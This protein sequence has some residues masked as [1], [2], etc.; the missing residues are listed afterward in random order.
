M[1]GDIELVTIQ[2]K[3]TPS[4]ES[5]TISYSYS[6]SDSDS[7]S[8]S[9]SSR[10]SSI[11]F[12]P[13]LS[14]FYPI[15]K[16][17]ALAKKVDDVLKKFIDKGRPEAEADNFL[18]TNFCVNDEA[19]SCSFIFSLIEI[20]EDDYVIE[21][22]LISMLIYLERYFIYNEKDC[23]HASNLKLFVLCGAWLATKTLEDEPLD[24]AKLVALSGKTKDELKALETEFL[25]KLEW[26]IDIS[27]EIHQKSCK[28]LD[29]YQPTE[30]AEVEDDELLGLAFV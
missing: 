9:L 21:N 5:P 13:V 15:K 30:C 11:Q 19:S 12:F 17:M 22:I 10:C 18:Q 24:Y 25:N 6:Y 23:L 28:K 7:D 4:I 26:N 29:A 8:D 3:K 16:R 2:I 1:F 27:D 20:M 14:K